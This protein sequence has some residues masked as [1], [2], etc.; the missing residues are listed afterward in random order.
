[1]ND[2][3]NVENAHRKTRKRYNLAGHAHALTFSCFQRQAFLTKDRSRLWFTE[4]VDRARAKYEFHVWAY[5]IMP[6][7]VHLLLWPVRPDYDVGDILNSIKLSVVKR[8]LIWVRR[9]APHFFCRM[10][11]RQP[12]G[13]V[14]YRFWQRGGGYDRNLIEPATAHRTIEYIHAN[15]V[16]RGLCRRPEE[17]PWSSAGDYAGLRN[18]PLSLDREFLPTETECR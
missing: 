16:R 7:H 12:N 13:K 5:V 14:H 1:M 4:A 10:Q 3:T 2:L 17:W 11:D 15:P 8:A 18:G 6:E 9:H